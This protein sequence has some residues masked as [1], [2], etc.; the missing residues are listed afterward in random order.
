VTPLSKKQSRTTEFALGLANLLVMAYVAYLLLA[1]L[2]S[3]QSLRRSAR[4]RFVRESEK[5]ASTLGYYLAERSRDLDRL[6]NHSEVLT[7]FQNKAL[8]MSMRY[9]LRASLTQV[10][11]LFQTVL[12][13]Q[14]VTGEPSFSSLV[15]IENDGLVLVRNADVVADGSTAPVPHG[16]GLRAAGDRLSFAIPISYRQRAV[17]FLLAEASIPPLLEWLNAD[18]SV[19]SDSWMG[20]VANR[21]LA[22]ETFPPLDP[23]VSFAH[24]PQPL[25]FRLETD[26]AIHCAEVPN[27]LFQLAVAAPADAIDGGFQTL[28]LAV[29]IGAVLAAM[30]LFLAGAV[31]RAQRRRADDALRESEENLSSLLLSMQDLVFVLDSDLVFRRIHAASPADLHTPAAVAIGKHV[32]EIGFPEPALAILRHAIRKVLDTGMP[33]RAEYSIPL[34]GGIQWFDLSASPFRQSDGQIGG[35]TCVVRNIT[36]IKR[37]QDDL[38]E[39]NDR[40]R[41]SVD[42]ANWLAEEAQAANLAKSNFLANMSHELRT[43]MN[44][45][46]GMTDLLLATP[47]SQEQ[48]KFAAS[49]QASADALLA[50][51]TDLLD[52]SKIEAGKLKIVESNF[53]LAQWIDQFLLPF[54]LRA[55]DKGLSLSCLLA[56]DLPTAICADPDRIRQILSNLVGNAIKFTPKGQVS[57]RVEL[58]P[59]PKSA[60]PL[61]PPSILFS[62]TDTG[63]GIPVGKQQFLFSKF[64]QVDPSS[65]RR[66]GG[67]GLG[68]AICKQ[69]AELMGGQTGFSSIDGQGSEF[70][71]SIPYK[72][73]DS[74]SAPAPNAPAP[75]FSADSRVLLVEDNA[76]NQLVAIG[77]LQKHA[78]QGDRETCLAAGM[79]DYVSKPL[80]PPELIGAIERWLAAPKDRPH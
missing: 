13:E 34:A 50:I 70:W 29:G 45:I 25:G 66:Y 15:L 41:E 47:L 72:P 61:L 49:V 44:G 5:S 6:A 42:R 59:R 69:L 8:G 28:Q 64:S 73:A 17:G 67:T 54:T 65:T 53:D 56:D 62:V 57:I 79:D 77:I 9:G 31:R 10:A 12:D 33:A 46:I 40:L 74:E 16:S 27:T 30:A 18:G 19:S 38:R 23:P 3:G 37:A 68:L 24:V 1:T 76:I 51:I 63:I 80:K 75:S 48:R 71:F 43:P 60:D 21:I 14:G 36:A 4:Q 39:T 11:S 20:L 32:D 7:Y 78:M 22:G 35:S 26:R 52:I 2:D 55:R 58:E